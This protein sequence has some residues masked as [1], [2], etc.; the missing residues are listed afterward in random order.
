[1]CIKCKNREM[2]SDVLAQVLDTSDAFLG[3]FQ[4]VERLKARG[5]TLDPDEQAVYDRL[6]RFVHADDA[7]Q[8]EPSMPEGL[9]DALKEAFPGA[10]VI[11]GTPEQIQAMLEQ[12]AKDKKQTH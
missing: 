12:A 11:V 1:M 6:S 4:L 3:A 8:A 10:Q 9:V 2:I 5:A 7:A